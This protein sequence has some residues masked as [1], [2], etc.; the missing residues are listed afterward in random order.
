MI[1]KLKQDIED[2]Y[3]FLDSL[4]SQEITY[5]PNTILD[6]YNKY[7]DDIKE[8]LIKYLSKHI[9]YNTLKILKLKLE[10]SEQGEPLSDEDLI[11][12]I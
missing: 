11:K 10:K 3:I 6:I 2:D 4:L 7:P 1:N 5:K 12:C 8:I 9:E